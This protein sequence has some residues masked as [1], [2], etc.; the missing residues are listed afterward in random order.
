[1]YFV[2]LVRQSKLLSVMRSVSNVYL[3]ACAFEKEQ[4]NDP[5]TPHLIST[6]DRTRAQGSVWRNAKLG[7]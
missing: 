1:M 2:F 7:S 5:K 4:P 6:Q 3:K